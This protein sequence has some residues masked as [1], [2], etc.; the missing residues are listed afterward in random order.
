MKSAISQTEIIAFADYFTHVRKKHNLDVKVS[1]D[2]GILEVMK[3][4]LDAALA[5]AEAPKVSVV[6]RGEIEA[7]E[8][9]LAEAD[10]IITTLTEQC[11]SRKKHQIYLENK[12]EQAEALM[13]EARAGWESELAAAVTAAREAAERK[14]KELA[15]EYCRLEGR[16]EAT[17]DLIDKMLRAA[18]V[19]LPAVLIFTMCLPAAH[20]NVLKSPPKRGVLSH[21]FHLG[22]GI[23][24][25]VP[26]Y[27]RDVVK[28]EKQ[29]IYVDVLTRNS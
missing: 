14:D 13:K 4:T 22:R 27:I 26:R 6:T 5:K 1:G 18:G 7:L 12:L 2:G 8:M 16:L 11:D 10:R 23:L 21:A 3:A 20:A 24:L 19:V 17:K 15:R 9:R 25:A 28:E 29:L